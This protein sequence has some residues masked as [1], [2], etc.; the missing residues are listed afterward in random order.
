MTKGND[1]KYRDEII[2]L[3][4]LWMFYVVTCDSVIFRDTAIQPVM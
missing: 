4:V 3:F 1:L 2:Y